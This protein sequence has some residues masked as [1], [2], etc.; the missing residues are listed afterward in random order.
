[1]KHSRMAELFMRYDQ[2]LVFSSGRVL[3]HVQT[4]DPMLKGQLDNHL[5]IFYKTSSLAP[6]K[7]HTYVVVY[8]TLPFLWWKTL[9]FCVALAIP[10]SR[11][12]YGGHLSRRQGALQHREISRQGPKPPKRLPTRWRPRTS[13]AIDVDIILMKPTKKINNLQDI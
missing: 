7:K 2:T 11:S 8:V 13:P 1:M 10:M 5:I 3:F 9:G 6:V 4:E 12:Q